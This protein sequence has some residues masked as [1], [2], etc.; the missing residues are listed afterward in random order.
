MSREVTRLSIPLR[1]VDRGPLGAPIG[2]AAGTMDNRRQF[3]LVVTATELHLSF[4]DRDGPR[5]AVDL[6]EV[7]KETANA[8]EQLLG[9][10]RGIK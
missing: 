3:N 5:F 2:G 6:N 8:V 7:A 10:S 1:E 9:Y 4:A